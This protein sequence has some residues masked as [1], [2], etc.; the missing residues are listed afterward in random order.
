MTTNNIQPKSVMSVTYSS[1]TSID[2]AFCWT[3]EINVNTTIAKKKDNMKPSA[4]QPESASRAALR[5]RDPVNSQHL[6]YMS[7]APIV[8]SNC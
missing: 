6:T 1:D 2:S 3:N 7:S 4:T 8:S 5:R